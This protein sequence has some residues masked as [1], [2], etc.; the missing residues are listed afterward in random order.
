MANNVSRI[1]TA[2]IASGA[3]IDVITV[4]LN[5]NKDITEITY[6]INMAP[7]SPAKILAGLKLWNKKPKVLPNIIKAKVN[8]SPVNLSWKKHITIVDK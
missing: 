3:K 6:P 4:V 5:P 8:S 1:G 2:R 7:E